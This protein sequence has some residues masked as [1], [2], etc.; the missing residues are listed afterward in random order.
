M[1]NV[2]DTVQLKSGGPIMTVHSIEDRDAVYC[3]WF[4]ANKQT[5]ATFKAAALRKVEMPGQRGRD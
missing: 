1:F 4:D 5:G 3:V 2:G